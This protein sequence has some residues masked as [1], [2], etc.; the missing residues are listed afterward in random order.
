MS[1]VSLLWQGGSQDRF[2]L[3]ASL[4]DRRVEATLVVD[5]ANYLLRANRRSMDVTPDTGINEV[6]LSVADLM[7]LVT[8]YFHVEDILAKRR[9][10]VTSEG[11]ALFE[12]V[13]PKREPCV[14]QSD[15]F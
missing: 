14:W 15:R 5:G 4:F 13:F 7:H 12:V 11:R 9:R 10:M 6:S 1:V 2:T 8:V 3:Q